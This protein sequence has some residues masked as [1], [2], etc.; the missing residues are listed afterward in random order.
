MVA[1]VGLV[2]KMSPWLY[3]VLAV[4]ALLALRTMQFARRDFRQSLFSLEREAARG[5]FYRSLGL[6]VGM[7]VVAGM[8]FAF[9]RYVVPLVRAEPQ[10]G[11]TPTGLLA[12]TPTL[13]PSE[14]TPE[15]TETATFVRPTRRP[16]ETAT[17]APAAT[18]RPPSTVAPPACANPKV[19][20]NSPGEGARLTGAAQIMGTA[21]INGFSFYKLEVGIGRNPQSWSVIGDLQ[22]SPVTDGLLGVLDTNALPPGDYALRLVVVDLTGNFPEPCALH[23]TIVR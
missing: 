12:P 10:T 15:P 5:R 11:P 20:I 9:G 8:V 18:I 6:F 1:L 22:R 23:F 4:V 2:A 7:F 3:A 14:I 16:E 17:V 19:R 13:G 21:A